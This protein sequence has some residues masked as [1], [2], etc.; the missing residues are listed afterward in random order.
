MISKSLFKV[1]REKLQALSKEFLGFPVPLATN[2]DYNK[3]CAVYEDLVNKRFREED[4]SFIESLIVDWENTYLERLPDYRGV[5]LIRH[6]MKEHDLKQ[7]DLPEIGYQPKVSLVLSGQEK[8][9][10]ISKK[11]L[12]KRFRLPAE[13]FDD[14]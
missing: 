3:A 2:D 9:S 4:A 6:L 7:K 5:D 13:M 12:S 11:R 14:E 8:L 10:Q 1:Y